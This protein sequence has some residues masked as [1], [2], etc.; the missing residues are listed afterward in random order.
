MKIVFLSLCRV[1]C[2]R[3]G[4]VNK[5]RI[6]DTIIWDLTQFISERRTFREIISPSSYGMKNKRSTIP[7]N[8]N[9]RVFDVDMFV[10]NVGP[11]PDY[12]AS[13][14]QKAALFIISALKIV[15][16]LHRFWRSVGRAFNGA[17][18]SSTS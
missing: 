1:S 12:T 13:Q 5:N 16:K 9:F 11:L 8:G 17:G 15:Q 14:T 10:Q 2:F 6:E 3:K 7:E 4:I 18:V